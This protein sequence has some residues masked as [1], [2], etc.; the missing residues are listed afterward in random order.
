LCFYSC[1][2]PYQQSLEGIHL[3]PTRFFPLASFLVSLFFLSFLCILCFC[4]FSA[5]HVR[6]SHHIY[7]SLSNNPQ[8]FPTS[9]SISQVVQF[10]RRENLLYQVQRFKVLNIVTDLINA[11]PGNGSVNTVH[12]ATIDEVVF[13]VVRAM[14]SAGDGPMNSQPDMSRVFCGVRAEK[15]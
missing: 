14:P 10:N 9:I 8:W 6:S 12:H 13:Y 2:S 1:H 4:F 7:N 15:L 11:L 5:R 3:C